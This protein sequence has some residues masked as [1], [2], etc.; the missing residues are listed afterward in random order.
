[1]VIL[2]WPQRQDPAEDNGDEEKVGSVQGA[3]CGAGQR[4]QCEDG[5]S[6]GTYRCEAC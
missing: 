4:R 6:G 5:K 1:M 2:I 3:D